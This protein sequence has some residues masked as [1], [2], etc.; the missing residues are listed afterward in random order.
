MEASMSPYGGQIKSWKASEVGSRAYEFGIV[1]GWS[2][3]VDTR[4][5]YDDL[6]EVNYD[7]EAVASGLSPRLCNTKPGPL[8][9]YIIF[10]HALTRAEREYTKQA[11]LVRAEEYTKILTSRVSLAGTAAMGSAACTKE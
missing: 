7:Y 2:I 5:I 1:D 10:F 8:M 11:S 9:R 6:Q 4:G 3:S